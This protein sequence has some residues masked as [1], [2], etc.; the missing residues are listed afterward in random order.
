MTCMN[1]KCSKIMLQIDV[2]ARNIIFHFAGNG[3]I[4]LYKKKMFSEKNTFL[5]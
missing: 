4:L 5:H 1:R 3:T 2:I